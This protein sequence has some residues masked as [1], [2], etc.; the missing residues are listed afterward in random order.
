[1]LFDCGQTYARFF[2]FRLH[3]K[4]AA[5]FYLRAQSFER[6]SQRMLEH[7]ISLDI[8]MLAKLLVAT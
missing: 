6:S 7:S 8:E 4:Q 2:S 5:L 3:I 1:L